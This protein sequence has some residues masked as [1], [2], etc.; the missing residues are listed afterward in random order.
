MSVKLV[1]D[2][3]AVGADND[4]SVSTTDAQSGS[5]VSQLPFGADF[6]PLVTLEPNQWKLSASRSTK[7]GKTLG[8][9]SNQ[10]SGETGEFSAPP[11][12]TVTFDNQYASLGI[13]LR[14]DPSTGEYS[15]NLTIRWYQGNTLLSEKTF[16]PDGVDYFCENTVTAFGR[17]E[18]EFNSTPLPGR[19]IR[20]SKI[21]FGISRTFGIDELR[22]VRL[23]EE[24]NLISAEVSINT[25]DF[26]LDSKSDS[27]F[28]FQKKQPIFAYDGDFL[29][30]AFYVDESSKSGVGL[31]EVSC[32]DAIGVLDDET[33]PA[34]MHNG[35]ALKTSLENVLS[36]YFEL[37][38][39]PEL[40]S[41]TL[42]GLQPAGTR[43]EALQQIAFAAMAVVDTSGTDKIKV[44]PVESE[45]PKEITESKIYLGS[46]T[47]TGSVVTA[48]R[49]T[50]HSYST[51]GTGETIDVNGVTYYHTSEVVTVSNPNV[52]ASD[53]QNIIEITDATL[54][55]PSN[56]SLVASHILDYYMRRETQSV[57]IVMA[58]EKP[59]DMIKTVTPWNTPFIGNISRMDITLSGISAANCEI[60]GTD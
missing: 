55:G 26:H 13:K 19:Y 18:F 20:L 16:F 10:M 34:V 41:K 40:E 54:V 30:G 7:A 21:Q 43:R 4:A 56:V 5:Q 37:D 6:V 31:Y 58:G 24:V 17:V 44:Y 57:K 42:T 52:T 59:G 15:D 53:K 46:T 27:E 38:L 49:V 51:T 3:I 47:K 28:L 39:A 11:K 32:V 1:Y 14:F 8:F 36:G 9:L 29:V 50:S 12:L 22:S 60:T 25:M 33:I 23:V 2:D 35:T 48:V 45:N